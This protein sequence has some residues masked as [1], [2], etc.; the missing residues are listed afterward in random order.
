MEALGSHESTT[1]APPPIEL[2]ATALADSS[3]EEASASDLAG[4]AQ[5]FELRGEV[6]RTLAMREQVNEKG[7][8]SQEALA[9]TTALGEDD[10]ALIMQT[11]TAITLAVVLNDD[12]KLAE[13]CL[14]VDAHDITGEPLTLV[15]P[16]LTLCRSFKAFVESPS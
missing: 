7:C 10:V 2:G 4:L 1:T 3:E 11:I 12:R 15:Y 14:A 16:F 6:I 13:A 5:E 8:F 9:L